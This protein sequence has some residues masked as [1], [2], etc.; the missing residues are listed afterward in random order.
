MNTLIIDETYE[1]LIKD[2]F[3]YRL[4]ELQFE[5]NIEI[6]L[7]IGLYITGSIRASGSIK[8]D[9][10]IE[11]GEWIEADG[12]IEAGGWVRA[13]EWIRAGKWIRADEWIESFGKKT[14]TLVN[15]TGFDYTCQ[16]WGGYIKIGCELHS[17]E[18]WASF[19]DKEILKIGGKKALDFW[20]KYKVFILSAPNKEYIGIS[21]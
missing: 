9:G 17:K 13:G 2:D 18:R 15:I 14:H 16:V 5:G 11:A 21:Q 12:S 19:S 6:K 3:K 4:E 8:S 10:S 20:N 7:P 1:G